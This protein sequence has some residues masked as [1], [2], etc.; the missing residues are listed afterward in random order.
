[1]PNFLNFQ[2]NLMSSTNMIEFCELSYKQNRIEETIITSLSPDKLDENYSFD[3]RRYQT[4]AIAANPSEF[5]MM[6][7]KDIVEYKNGNEDYK[8][9]ITFR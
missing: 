4:A 3:I 8:N 7:L 9:Q 2:I 6:D 1:M 5:P